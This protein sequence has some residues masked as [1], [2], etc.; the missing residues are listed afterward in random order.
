MSNA[1]HITM[2][3][4]A[5]RPIIVRRFLES[6]SPTEEDN[7]CL[8]WTGI[9]TSRGYGT[10]TAKPFA[11]VSAHRL[12]FFLAYGW[13]PKMVCHRCD[14]PPCVK[15]EHL[16][17]GDAFTNARDR[18]LRSLRRQYAATTP[19]MIDQVLDLR[20]QGWTLSDIARE[21][22]STDYTVKQII[23]QYGTAE[24]LVTV[25]T[26]YIE[27]DLISVLD[28]KAQGKKRIDIASHLGVGSGQIG[29]MQKR[30]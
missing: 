17:G 25:N 14:N 28:L 16:Y 15:P 20:N 21:V 26:K 2:Q 27:D 11:N 5:R 1:E 22:D 10:L 12:S 9:F 30:K 7:G 13:W 18:S 19:E 3:F 4:L 23:K 8:L 6:V 29:R 24:M